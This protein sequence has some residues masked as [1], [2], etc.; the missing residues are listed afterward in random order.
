M[1]VSTTRRLAG[2]KR[3]GSCEMPSELSREVTSSDQSVSSSDDPTAFDEVS[4]R[5]RDD[6]V[7]SA[8][9]IHS[10]FA[11]AR[12]VQVLSLRSQLGRILVVTWQGF[13]AY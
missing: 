6:A 1:I 11:G 12:D 8:T 5:Q 7:S 2:D 4:E 3:R 10:E 9:S 13:S